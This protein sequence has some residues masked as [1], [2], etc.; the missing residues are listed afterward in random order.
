MVNVQDGK[1]KAAATYNSASDHYNDLALSFW[2]YHG[3]RTIDNL[4]LNR[5]DTILDV[6]CGAGSSAIPAA[7]MVGQ[8]GKVIG[9][10]LAEKLLEHARKKGSE[11]SLNNTE[12]RVGDMEKLEDYFHENDD[13]QFDAVVCVF[14]I[15]FVNDMESQIR[16]LWK[17]VKSNGGKLAITTWGPRMFEPAYSGWNN[18]LKLEAPDLY[19]ASNPWDRI[20]D[21]NSVRRLIQ[22]G[23]TPGTAK[24]EVLEE[25]A[26]QPLKAPDDWWTVALGSG[27]RW[28]IDQLD[29]PTIQKIR[30]ANIQFVNTNNIKAIE[31]N[32]IYSIAT[33]N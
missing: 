9:I 30:Q 28:A 14:A 5:G 16:K 13:A 21:I 1:F 19:A 12:F 24:I 10:D 8:E 15:F 17:L 20:T 33:K 2:D 29:P 22:N 11:R 7:E 31:T 6:A 32:A 27:L 23:V 25:H 18:I 4:K 26:T 3:R